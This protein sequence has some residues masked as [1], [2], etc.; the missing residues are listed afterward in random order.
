LCYS[1]DLPN[2]LT[3]VVDRWVPELRYYCPQLP[4]IL[5]GT[6]K[7]LRNDAITCRRLKLQGESRACRTEDGQTIAQKIRSAF[8][9]ECSCKTFENINEIFETAAKLS[10]DTYHPNQSNHSR[11]SSKAVASIKS[12]LEI[13]PVQIKKKK[14]QCSIL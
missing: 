5:V 12:S 3:N 6:K 13:K 8:F 11:K 4:I 10:K 1:I 9:F 14:K 7:D 2:S